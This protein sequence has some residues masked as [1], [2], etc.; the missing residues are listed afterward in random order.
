MSKKSRTAVLTLPGLRDGV[1]RFGL[2]PFAQMVGVR[3]PTFYDWQERGRI[4][5]ERCPIVAKLTGVPRRKI[6]P[7]VYGDA[8]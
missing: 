5:A 8:A 7:D 1:E 2:Y 3:V 6:R 4:P